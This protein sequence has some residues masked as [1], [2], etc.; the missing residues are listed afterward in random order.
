[1]HNISV[2]VFSPTSKGESR[3]TASSLRHKSRAVI[4]LAAGLAL[5]ACSHSRP[6]A[7]TG[8]PSAIVDRNLTDAADS[9]TH[10]LSVL[11]GSR[12]NLGIRPAAATGRLYAPGSLKYDGPLEGALQKACAETGMRLVVTGSR[13]DV[14][15]IVH[16]QVTGRPW[17]KVFRAIGE[18]TGAAQR[19]RLIE[20]AKVVE[21][22]YVNPAT[23][24]AD[25]HQGR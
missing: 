11:T 21:L 7:G 24:L 14:P 3:L 12:Q 18:Q 17:L 10:D 19:V 25:T 16:V 2:P 22:A 4:F 20:A 6:A 8:T 9:I 13:P 1:M 23:G 15:V 5:T